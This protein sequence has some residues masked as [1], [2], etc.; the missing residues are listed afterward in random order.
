LSNNSLV[1]VKLCSKGSSSAF[2]PCFTTSRL[3]ITTLSTSKIAEKSKVANA[4]RHWAARLELS[5][6]RGHDRTLVHS[7]HKGPMLVQRPFYPEDDG[8]CH[9]YVL[10]P[11]GGVAGGDCLELRI[12][13]GQNARCVLTAPGATKFYR[14]AHGPGRQTIRIEVGDG[15]VCEFLPMETIL[16]NGCNAHT[17]TEVNLSDTATFVGWDIASLGRPAARERFTDGQYSQRYVVTRGGRPIWFERTAID[18]NSGILK[19]AH[20][21]NDFPIFGTM[22]YAGDLPEDAV[23]IVRR[24]LA[25]VPTGHASITQMQDVI[26]CR[27]LGPKVSSARVFFL[28]IWDNLRN[29]GQAKCAC[30]PRIWMT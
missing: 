24:H 20:G 7:R 17:Q 21:L 23:E 3:E 14:S 22:V 27:Y 25:P 19:A 30:K 10:H 16:F 9:S 1:T 8:T 28:A 29:L 5:F 2:S 15:G 11:P 18:G 13:V 26:V 4:Q 6:A 12:D